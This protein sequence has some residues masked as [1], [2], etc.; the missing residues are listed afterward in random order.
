MTTQ[1]QKRQLLGQILM[2]GGFLSSSN[3]VRALAE[4]KQTNELLGQ[5]LVRM[6]VVGPV[7]IKAALSVQDHLG[8][9]EDAIRSAAGTRQML[10]ALLIMAGRITNEQLEH[11]IAVQKITGEKLG[12]VFTRLGILKVEQLDNLL[13]FQKNQTNGSTTSNPFRLGEI[14]VTAGYITR[15]QLD[16]ALLK[17]YSSAKKL[18]EVLVEDGYAAPH[19]VSHGIRLQQSLI[20]AALAAILAC[21]GLTLAGCGSGGGS[22]GGGVSQVEKLPNE[23]GKTLTNSYLTVTSDD[24]NLAAPNFY[25]STVNESFWSIQANIAKNLLDIDTR[26]VIRID[27]P[28]INGGWPHL[29]T[30]FSIEDNPQFAKFPGQILVFNGSP[31]TMSKVE[32]G[33]ITFTPDSVSSDHVSGSFDVTM[34]D[35]ASETVPLPRHHMKGAF[36]FKMGEYG[37][38]NKL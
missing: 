38:I 32:Q 22:A 6:G 29:N 11:A 9:L 24:Y 10:G 5:I 19:H 28:K 33:T 35:Y 12:E 2:D 14:L 20:T 30:V 27:V 34:T 25:Y 16:D 7:E 17:Q 1:G 15:G 13:A 8:N 4:Q 21:G 3:L 26:C 18:G 36:N 31:S 23:A 37:P